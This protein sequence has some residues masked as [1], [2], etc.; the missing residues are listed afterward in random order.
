M[1]T[2]ARTLLEPLADP[3][4]AAPMTRYM[5]GVAP[6]LGIPS[7]VRRTTTRAW[8]RAA[9]LAQD[10]LLELATR[11]FGLPEREYSYLAIDLLDRHRRRLGADTLGQLRVLALT[12]PW[13]DTVDAMS[14][15]IGRTALG[16]PDWDPEIVT[17]AGDP[18]LWARRIALVF[19]VGRRDRVNLD[20]LFAACA[21]NF[22]DK[23]FFMRKGIGWGLRDAARA[24]PEQVRAFVLAN[25]ER[26]SG[27]SLREATKHLPL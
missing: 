5:K 20:L 26:M 19:Q 8:V 21:A 23:D 9:A 15:V 3:E 11:L 18:E 22:A 14:G 6:Y 10:E 12:R 17:W 7:P 25:R 24:H 27:L 16:H 13:W 1:V 2:G 4:R